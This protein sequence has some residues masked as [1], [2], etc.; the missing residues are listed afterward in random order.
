MSGAACLWLGLDW[1]GAGMSNVYLPVIKFEN[2]LN[3]T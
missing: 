3:F 2:D 1:S